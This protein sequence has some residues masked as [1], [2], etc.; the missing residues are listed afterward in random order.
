MM[1]LNTL[2]NVTEP[3]AD[4]FDLE[5]HIQQCWSIIEDIKLLNEGVLERNMTV[6]Q[7]SNVLLGLESLYELKFIKLWETF[8]TLV[9]HKKIIC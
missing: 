9:N 2:Q 5:Q 3:G 7:I 6:D 1:D 8:E 4:R